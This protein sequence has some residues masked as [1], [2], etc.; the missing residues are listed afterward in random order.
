MQCGHEQIGDLPTSL[1]LLHTHRHEL[2][3]RQHRRRHSEV[4]MVSTAV[5][6]F[7]Y[8]ESSYTRLRSNTIISKEAAPSLTS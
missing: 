2:G 3:V 6:E 5:T 1:P 8:V 7:W 4:A